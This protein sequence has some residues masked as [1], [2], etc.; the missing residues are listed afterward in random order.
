MEKTT[1]KIP[2]S[3]RRESPAPVQA[4][5]RPVTFI[6]TESEKRS[7]FA[8]IRSLRGSG[9]K[10]SALVEMALSLPFMLL[11]MTGIFSFSVALH[12]KL[13]LAE[14]VSNGGRVLA[15]D[16][17]DTNPCSTAAAAIYAAAPTL[18]QSRFTLTFVLN[19]ISTGASCA[20]PGGGANANLVTGGNANVTASYPCVI[21][22]YNFGFPNCTLTS[23]L[24]EIVQ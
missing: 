12:Q 6:G 20:G 24:T 2:D 11:I 1:M 9:T 5:N 16:R 14:A 8:R 18:A 22:V 10:G 23:Q 15:V 3:G 19:G 17:G 7:I 4:E 21:G 13:E